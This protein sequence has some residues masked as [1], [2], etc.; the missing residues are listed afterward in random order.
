MDVLGVPTAIGYEVL[1][2]YKGKKIREFTSRMLGKYSC[3]LSLELHDRS[4]LVVSGI[5]GLG[6][7]PA[8]ISDY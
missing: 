6:H 3:G 5:L 8:G 1:G 2:I 7:G 4:N